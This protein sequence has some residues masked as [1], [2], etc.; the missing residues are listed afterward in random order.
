MQAPSRRNISLAVTGSAVTAI[1]VAVWSALP[2]A[3]QPATSV[4]YQ[5]G[6]SATMFTGQA[7]DACTAPSLATMTAWEAS[8]YRAVGVYIA[9]A[10]RSCQQPR[11]TA[12]WVRAVTALGWRLLP[13]YKG[14]QAPCGGK[15]TDPKIKLAAAVSEGV[16]AADEAVAAA[17]ALG[18]FGGS[19][20]YD[21]M[22]Y[23]T[24]GIASCRTAALRF[25][26]GWTARLHQLGFLAGEYVQLNSGAHDLAG[27]YAS[28][29]Y[30][31]PDA[32]WVAR[33]DGDRALTGWAGIPDADWAAHGRAK[34]YQP[35]HNETYGG[36]TLNID[37]DQV[38]GPVATVGYQYAVTGTAPLS[39]RSGPSASDPVV[40][41]H[42][43]AS[44]LEVVCQTHG[45]P[46]GQT[47]VWDKLGD[48]T[49]VTD[50]FVSTPSRTS[51]SPPLPR[52]TYPYQVTGAA[53]VHLRTG[54]GGSFPS[55]GILPAGALAWVTCQRAGT[56]SGV[57]AIWDKLTTG[58]W[59]S[60]SHVATPSATSF[61]PPIP[62]C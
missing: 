7:F 42:A 29:A 36:A 13:I 34:Q 12:P 32:V 18:V 52:C 31:R 33:Y 50:R 28:S 58:R 41:T 30:A 15:P 46:T 49:Y 35:G 43:P 23:Y 38:D 60:D 20:I 1:A 14:L 48:G 26:S 21:D 40:M 5:A 8:P 11:L 22:E 37:N 44:S 3:A 51:F 16:A 25:L 55:A 53:G 4:G 45:Q 57:S 6:A 59:V 27:V 9:G 24:P 19:A 56:T 61:S 10:D 39:A 62:G 17:K 54:P 47:S 2:A